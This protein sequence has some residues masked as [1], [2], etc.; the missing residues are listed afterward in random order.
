MQNTSQIHNT[1]QMKPN[2]VCNW[3]FRRTPATAAAAAAASSNNNTAAATGGAD[4]TGLAGLAAGAL[5]PVFEFG[6]AK[7]LL[8]TSSVEKGWFLA[9]HNYGIDGG[10][11]QQP[12]SVY[13]GAGVGC[14][15][16]TSAFVRPNPKRCCK[17]Q[18]RHRS[19]FQN[20]SQSRINKLDPILFMIVCAEDTFGTKPLFSHYIS[21]LKLELVYII[22]YYIIVLS[23]TSSRARSSMAPWTS[24][25]RAAPG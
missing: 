25:S 13:T 3:G 8:V 23:G 10:L 24:T 4:V 21:G 22:I 18:M 11:L 17:L 19:P 1:I 16:P 12:M 14:G 15:E 6:L 20:M 7:Y 9:N 5:D 2:V